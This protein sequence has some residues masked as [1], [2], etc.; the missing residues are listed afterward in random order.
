[1]G[2]S[3]YTDDVIGLVYQCTFFLFFVFFPYHKQIKIENI[4]IGMRWIPIPPFFSYQSF[5]TVYST[6][7]FWFISFK[8]LSFSLVLL[9][10]FTIFSMTSVDRLTSL[11]SYRQCVLEFPYS[12]ID[13][14]KKC[15]LSNISSLFLLLWYFVCNL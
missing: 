5:F 12:V 9:K 8:H 3:A 7:C 14:P 11:L 2:V 10:Y 4:P 1:M 15:V 6:H 13:Y